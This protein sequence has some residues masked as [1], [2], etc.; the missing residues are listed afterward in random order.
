MVVLT[1][2]VITSV[3]MAGMTAA[4]VAFQLAAPSAQ[5]WKLINLFSKW[6]LTP[7]A[8]VA[9]GSGLVLAGA[10]SW[11]LLRWR[12]VI[13]KL[14]ISAMLTGVGLVSIAG[15]FDPLTV[16][17]ARCCALVALACLVAVSVVKPWGRTPERGAR[18][19]HLAAVS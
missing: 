9:F 18:S 2:H 4:L 5:V 17:A 1:A 12:W 7:T 3:G 8:G 10:G 6:V 11:G 19:E 14:Q 15:W 13:V 16:L